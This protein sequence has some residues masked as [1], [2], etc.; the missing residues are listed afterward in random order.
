M[1]KP[2]LDERR[3]FGYSV[4]SLFFLGSLVAA[5]KGEPTDGEKSYC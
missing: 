4:G 3:L 1:K 2:P 5:K